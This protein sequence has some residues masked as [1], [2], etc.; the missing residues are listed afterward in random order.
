[1]TRCNQAFSFE[2]QVNSTY[3]LGLYFDDRERDRCHGID[4]NPPYLHFKL[5]ASASSSL[6]L[7]GRSCLL[8]P[9][10]GAEYASERKEARDS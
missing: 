9:L 2:M 5:P 8:P 6:G 10:A 1:M 4:A 7:Y 3:T